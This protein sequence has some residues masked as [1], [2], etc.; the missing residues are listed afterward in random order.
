MELHVRLW[1]GP[2][3][4]VQQGTRGQ[5]R[6]RRRL[7]EAQ[8][9]QLR[10]S[11]RRGLRRLPCHHEAGSPSSS[12]SLACSDPAKLVIRL[13]RLVVNPGLGGTHQIPRD[14]LISLLSQP[15]GSQPSGRTVRLVGQSQTLSPPL[16]QP[17]LPLV[18]PVI[19]HE[20]HTSLCLANCS[21]KSPDTLR[22]HLE[23]TRV[24]V[25]S[26]KYAKLRWRSWRWS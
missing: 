6:R 26:A 9:P 23:Q 4:Q 14:A 19:L 1:A 18:P 13:V 17:P 3:Q 10:W 15:S 11:C 24:T 20:P 16:N 21:I 22:Y 7:M 8:M 2:Q 25:Y 5:R 12:T